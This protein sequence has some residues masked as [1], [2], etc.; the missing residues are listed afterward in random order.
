[1][2]P[3][4]PEVTAFIEAMNDLDYNKNPCETTEKI[5]AVNPECLDGKNVQDLVDSAIKS[6]NASCQ[7]FTSWASLANKCKTAEER[8][9]SPAPTPNPDTVAIFNKALEGK[10]PGELADEMLRVC[11][12]ETGKCSQLGKDQLAKDNPDKAELEKAF[13]AT[14]N[15]LCRAPQCLRDRVSENA[16][17]AAIT[18]AEKVKTACD[19]IAKWIAGT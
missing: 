2:K 4:A 14:A 15:Y 11:K 17:L 5:K 13:D 18:G 8:A 19:Q 10:Q 16:T 3:E 12:C 6:L 1:M 7:C 9:A